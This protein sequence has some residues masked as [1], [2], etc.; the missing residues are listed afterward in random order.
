[1]SFIYLASPYS[2]SDK[3]IMRDRFHKAMAASASLMKDGFIIFSPIVH[4]HEMAEKF[5]LP[6]DY[7]FWEKYDEGMIEAAEGYYILCI[8][9]WQESNGISKE[10][11]FAILN[12]KKRMWVIPQGS[13][14]FVSA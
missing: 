4:C 6:T 13:T 9:G 2:H 12:R 7:A 1:M 14:Y 5:S 3:Q 8:D 11:A 10:T